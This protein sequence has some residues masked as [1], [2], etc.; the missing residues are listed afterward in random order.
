MNEEKGAVGERDRQDTKPAIQAW[1]EAVQKPPTI[2]R[3]NFYTD[4][5][6]KVKNVII[7]EQN[8]RSSEN[9][10]GWRDRHKLGSRSGMLTFKAHLESRK[11]LEI[12]NKFFKN[13]AKR[14]NIL[15]IFDLVKSESHTHINWKFHNVLIL[16]CDGRT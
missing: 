7:G 3:K 9:M 13:R 2:K 6:K 14:V 11:I 1:K 12:G 8:M 4:F 5:H 16:L 10:D 15:H